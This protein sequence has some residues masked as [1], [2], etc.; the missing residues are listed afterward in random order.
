MSAVAAGDRDEFNGD[1]TITV[2][3]AM[4]KG[5]VY[6]HEDSVVVARAAI[7]NGAAGLVAISG[8]VV[9][10]KLSTAAFAIGD[11]VYADTGGNNNVTAVGPEEGLCGIALEV[12]G[13]PSSKVLILLVNP[14][15]TLT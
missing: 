12:A 9:V 3:E 1:L 10:D 11:K 7:A 4:T 13:N 14:L 15:A 2:G 5:A 6:T 8:P